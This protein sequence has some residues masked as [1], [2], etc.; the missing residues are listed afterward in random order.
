MKI[1]Y[2]IDNKEHTLA[3]VLNMLLKDHR[4]RSLDIASAF[5]SIRDLNCSERISRTSEVFVSC[6]VLSQKAV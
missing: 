6:S 1:P 5:F 2:V 3:D 4:G